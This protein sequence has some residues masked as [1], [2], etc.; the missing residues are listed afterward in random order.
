MVDYP[1]QF[2][3]ALLCSFSHEVAHFQCVHWDVDKG[4]DFSSDQLVF[5]PLQL[6][7]QIVRELFEVYLFSEVLFLLAVLTKDSSIVSQKF[8]IAVALQAVVES[9]LKS[10]FVFLIHKYLFPVVL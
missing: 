8:L 4:I 3:L 1:Y 10:R 7:A 2:V 5:K 6:D 9:N